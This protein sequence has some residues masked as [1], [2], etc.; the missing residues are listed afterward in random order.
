[1]PEMTKAKQARRAVTA[2]LFSLI[3]GGLVGFAGLLA[4]VYLWSRLW[5]SGKRPDDSDAYLCGLVVGALMAL[6][7]VS[8]SL[9]KFWPRNPTNNPPSLGG[10]ARACLT[11]LPHI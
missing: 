10:K 6:V 1:M 4:G 7:A 8:G 2:I 9:W 11:L 5:S 3:M